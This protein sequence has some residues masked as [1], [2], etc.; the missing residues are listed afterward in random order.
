MVRFAFPLTALMVMLGCGRS[1]ESASPGQAAAGS[2]ADQAADRGWTVIIE[3]GGA[4]LGLPAL[5]GRSVRGQQL[6]PMYQILGE[7]PSGLIISLGA[8]GEIRPGDYPPALFTASW[9]E[10]AYKC[11]GAGSEFVVTVESVEPLSGTFRGPAR[12]NP[13]DDTSHRTQ[14]TL[15]GTFQD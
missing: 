7:G 5:A 3:E 15:S 2:G 12:C 11:V 9:K 1:A 10:A 8:V 14:V 13:E 4:E 6:G